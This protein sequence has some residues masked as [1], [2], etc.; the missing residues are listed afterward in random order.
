MTCVILF[1][2][3]FPPIDHAGLLLE[4]LQRIERFTR[5]LAP[6]SCP[7]RLAPCTSVFSQ[8]RNLKPVQNVPNNIPQDEV[9]WTD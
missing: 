9:V 5:R 3:E 2:M 1:T 7:L 8:S 6:Y 4:I